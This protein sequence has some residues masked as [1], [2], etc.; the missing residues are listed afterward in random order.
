LLNKYFPNLGIQYDFWSG[1]PMFAGA[2]T[3]KNMLGVLCLVSGLFFFWDTVTR[4][5]DRKQRRTRRIIM[6]NF[7]FI[8][9]T[10]WLL[11]LANS[12]T[13]R[14]CLVIGCLVIAAVH[15]SWGKRHPRLLK[16]LI[17]ASFCLYLILAFGFDINA[18]LAPAVGRNSTLTDRTLIWK[19][20]LNMHTN[21]IVGTGYDSFWLGSR[22]EW[23]ART[24]S[25]INESHNGYLEVY[26]N[27]GLIGLFLI[28]ALLITS[29]R[30]IC[31]KLTP[32]SNIA[33]LSMALW[34]VALFYNMTEAAIK[35]SLMWVVF[36]L[37]AIV[38][39]A[40]AEDRVSSVAPFHNAGATGRFPRPSL[41]SV[42]QR[43]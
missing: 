4:W 11:Y 3:H 35:I 29:Y 17:P 33:S 28:V 30:N 12:A 25:Y 37:A 16:A 26:L 34:T 22:L 13:S 31:R 1:A 36:L 18:K 9:M 24:Y 14:V 27:L 7:A 42:S 40:P 41:K 32:F 5:S 38:V 39:R 43:R 21:P 10:L 23:V 20:L 8:V 6:V 19:M 2:T 15:S